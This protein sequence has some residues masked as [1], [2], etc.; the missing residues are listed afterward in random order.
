MIFVRK[1]K[2]YQHTKLDKLGIFLNFLM[3]IV[4]IPSL[5]VLCMAFGIVE[6]NVEFVNQI[7]YNIPAFAILCLALSVVFRRKGFSKTGFFIQF[8]TIIPFVLALV[9][10]AI[11]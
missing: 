8:G 9:A 5:S 7:T 10:E 6:S 3:G 4:V 11:F 1:D 2:E